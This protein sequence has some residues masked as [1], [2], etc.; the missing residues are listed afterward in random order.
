MLVLELPFVAALI[1]LPLLVFPFLAPLAGVVT[2][3]LDPI[4]PDDGQDDVV[5]HAARQSTARATCAA[6]WRRVRGGQMRTRCAAGRRGGNP[7]A[8]PAPVGRR[9]RPSWSSAGWRA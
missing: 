9:R 5:A 6:A 1:A 2:V 8:P 7:F 4:H 3:A